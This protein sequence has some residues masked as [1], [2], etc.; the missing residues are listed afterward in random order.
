MLVMMLK[1]QS[2]GYTF[3]GSSHKINALLFVDDVTLVSKLPSD[4]QRLCNI[5]SD[6]CQWSQLTIKCPNAAV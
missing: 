3:S 2:F 5:V 4:L 6:W 1:T